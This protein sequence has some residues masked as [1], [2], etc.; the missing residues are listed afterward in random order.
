MD[1]FFTLSKS[2][3][4]FCRIFSVAVEI[5]KCNYTPQSAIVVAW[6]LIFLVQHAC[7][8]S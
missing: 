4:K 7:Y 6:D 8:Y 5:L 3:Q 1:Y 2:L